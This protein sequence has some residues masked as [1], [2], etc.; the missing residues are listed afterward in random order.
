[1]AN[2]NV[3]ALTSTQR[4]GWASRGGLTSTGDGAFSALAADGTTGATLTLGSVTAGSAG[5]IR[6]ASGT[7]L[8]PNG[9]GGLLIKNN[10]GTTKVSISTA[11][12]ATFGDSSIGGTGEVLALT[13]SFGTTSVRVGGGG[14]LQLGGNFSALGGHI[15]GGSDS[16]SLSIGTLGE[17]R[18]WRDA[19]HVFA[20]RNGTDAQAFRVYNTYT[21]ASNYERFFTRWSS[22]ICEL[23][24]EAGGTGSLRNLDFY[25]GGVHY[26]RMGSGSWWFN[27]E[28]TI[29]GSV[30]VPLVRLLSN[31]AKELTFYHSNAGTNDCKF[32]V[33]AAQ[34]NAANGTWL[35]LFGD[36]T[37]SLCKIDTSTL[38]TGTAMPLAIMANGN[39]AIRIG[40]SGQLGFFGVTPAARSTGYTITNKTSDKVLDCNSTTL[41]E[42]A[43][44]LGTLIDDLKTYGIIGG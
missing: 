8:A 11:A 30:A 39:E 40:T 28:V 3:N 33:T 44:V 41:D 38:G 4:I 5:T 27:Y 17:T 14:Q 24:V 22:N 35:Q 23:G 26:G 1:M 15:N 42:V 18:L 36:G 25:R 16:G 10:A 9:D 43:D 20:Q 29:A 13:S 34:T 37:N 6:F 7:Q 32:R 12:V 2:L 31:T 19:A 21:D